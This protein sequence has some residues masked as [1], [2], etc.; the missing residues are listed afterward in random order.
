MRFVALRI[1]ISGP[2]SKD[3]LKLLD[4]ERAV[5]RK[6]EFITTKALISELKKIVRRASHGQKIYELVVKVIDTSQFDI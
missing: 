1:V 5:W 4:H 6:H 3:I 2:L